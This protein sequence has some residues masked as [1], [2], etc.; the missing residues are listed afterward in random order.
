MRTDVIRPPSR[1]NVRDNFSLR[2]GEIRKRRHHNEQQD[3]YLDD[4]CHQDWVLGDEL[5]GISFA[6]F[7][8]KTAPAGAS[9]NSTVLDAAAAS[10][11]APPSRA[12]CETSYPETFWR[13]SSNAASAVRSRIAG[14]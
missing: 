7:A 4:R 3:G 9:Y 11:A 8:E 10:S 13:I 6:S 14:P 5:H 12:T 2:P 1:L